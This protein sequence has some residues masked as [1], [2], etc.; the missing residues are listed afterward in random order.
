MNDDE[1]VEAARRHITDAVD[2]LDEVENHSKGTVIAL[3]LLTGARI[4]TDARL[5]QSDE[6]EGP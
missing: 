3:A 1:A 4:F 2:A 6:G 5:T